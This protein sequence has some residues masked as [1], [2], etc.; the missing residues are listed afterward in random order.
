MS[1]GDCRAL[2]ASCAE[3]RDLDSWGEFD[4]RF[5]DRLV[6]G[7]RRALKSS[8][9]V[10]ERTTV[11]DLVQDVYCRL[12]E[13]DGRVLRLC[14]GEND[15]QVGCYLQTVAE[16]VALDALR[17]Q[18]AKKR[19]GG[20]RMSPISGSAESKTCLED[21]WPD[22]RRTT[23]P[24]EH[25]LQQERRRLF[26]SKCRAALGAN[27]ARRDLYILYLA[28][29]EECSSSEISHRLVGTLSP[30]GVDSRISR[31]RQRLRDREGIELPRRRR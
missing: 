6:F 1:E 21:L 11:E 25:L 10:P 29:F 12:L 5:R 4:R 7:V 9:L 30:Y 27:G 16:R 24:E 19:G 2:V 3:G 8:G 26:F 22:N 28:L 23:S 18:A 31:M 14:R 15:R 17:G 20:F 13:R